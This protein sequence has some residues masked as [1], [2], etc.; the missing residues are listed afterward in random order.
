[1]A[2]FGDSLFRGLVGQATCAGC[3]AG[4]RATQPVA[5]DLSGSAWLGGSAGFTEVLDFLEHGT[6]VQSKEVPN[7]PHGGVRLR[8]EETRA[9]A[10]YILSLGTTAGAEP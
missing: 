8:P 9:L 10:V 5:P 3:H 2:A 1:M 6:R 4:G 7:R